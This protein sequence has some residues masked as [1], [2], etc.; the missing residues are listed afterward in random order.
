M[1][2]RRR[3]A[4]RARNV[5]AAIPGVAAVDARHRA[6]S[7]PW[8]LTIDPGASRPR[9]V[10]RC[11]RRS[12]ASICRWRRSVPVVPVA[13]GHLPARR[14]GR[15]PGAG[16]PRSTRTTSGRAHD[17]RERS[18]RDADDRLDAS[19]RCRAPAGSVVAA[20][21]IRRPPAVGAVHR[22]RRR[23]RRWPR[24]SRCT[25]SAGRS[26]PRL[27]GATDTPALFIALFWLAPQVNDQ[28]TLPSVV[29]FLAI[30]GAAARARV[31]VRRD[32]RRAGR[33]HAAA[34]PVAADPSRRRHQ[35]QVRRGLRGHRARARG[36]WSRLI[37]AFG[38][39]RLGIVPGG[40]RAA[41]RSCCGCSSR[42]STCRCG[43][44][45]GCCCRWSSVGRRR[46]RSIGFGA[47]LLLTFFGGLIVSLIG[48]IVAPIDRDRRRSSSQHRHPAD[49]EPAPAG[50]A[51]SRG[52]AHAAQPA[53]L[54][55]LDAGHARRAT[56]RRSSGSRRCSRSTRASSWCGRRSWRW[57][58]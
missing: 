3:R 24:R 35:R 41:A 53:G 54:D 40:G 6:E 31:R 19:G 8:I 39:I 46:R 50:H 30:V 37:A 16:Q 49:A 56:R 28:I 58:P 14:R 32:Q 12:P 4:A 10:R 51:L 22:A 23:P 11:W 15:R 7:D 27:E 25:S 38:L 5:L 21:G 43:S 52:V 34:A 13:R 29:G 1:S 20:Q 26:G 42:S 57:S 2:D 33:G 45:S 47:W 48:G 9:S 44:R 55:R 18:G 36:Q 17:R